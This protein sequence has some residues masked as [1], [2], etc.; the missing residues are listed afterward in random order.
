MVFVDIDPLKRIEDALREEHDFIAAVLETVHV[1]VLVIDKEGRII[2]FNR[3]CRELSGY[4][5]EEVRGRRP[6]ISCPYPRKPRKY[7]RC[8]GSF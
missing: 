4:T 2:H 7:G 5:L 1:L 3:A 8:I 6:G